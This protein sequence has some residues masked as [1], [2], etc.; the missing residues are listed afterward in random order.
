LEKYFPIIGKLSKIFSNHWKK[1]TKF[2]NHWKLYFQSLENFSGRPPPG[3]VVPR[4]CRGSRGK[5]QVRPDA[6]EG[7]PRPLRPA[8]A[9]AAAPNAS[10]SRGIGD[11]GGSPEDQSL[12]NEITE[13]F[14]KSCLF[15]VLLAFPIRAE[16]R[17]EPPRSR[18]AI[19]GH[20]G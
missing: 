2:S 9:T 16:R 3:V 4:P 10:V 19:G 11:A 12:K 14:P 20:R 1:R 18:V 7:G 8:G 6:P 15:S 17:M 5:A 13:N